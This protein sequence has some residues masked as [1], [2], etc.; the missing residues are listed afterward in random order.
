MRKNRNAFF[1]ESNMN[2]QGYNPM[3]GN[4]PYQTNSSNSFYAGP[5]IP[6]SAAEYNDITQ[7]LAKLERQ[8][9]RLEH[10]VNK[11]ESTTIKSTEDFESTTNNVYMI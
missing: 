8:L 7:R 1:A 5:M 4:I 2:Y 6:N 3:A 9:N 11:L 10:R